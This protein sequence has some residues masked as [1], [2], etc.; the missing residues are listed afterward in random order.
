M[1]FFG[2]VGCAIDNKRLDFGGDPDHGMHPGIFRRKIYHY[3]IPRGNC[4]K[5]YVSNSI[6]NGLQRLGD[7]PWRGFAL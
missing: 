5:F 6:N 7:L 3:G 2:G 4:E 1:K